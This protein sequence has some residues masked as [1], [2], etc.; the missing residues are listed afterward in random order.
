MKAPCCEPLLM[1]I[2]GGTGDLTHRMV[3]PA[4]FRLAARGHLDPKSQIVVA[5]RRA[6]SDEELRQ[7]SMEAIDQEVQDRSAETAAW[8]RAS[9]HYRQ[10]EQQDAD[11]MSVFG[12]QLAAFEKESGL[13]G[14]RVFYL[15]LPPF[16]FMPTVEALGEAGLAR[17]GGWTRIVVEKPFGR[18]L[19]SAE[20]LNALLHRYFNEPQIF[21][22]DHYLG[23]ETVQ[24]LLVFRLANPIFE[25]LWNRDRIESVQITVSETLGVENR[26]AFY[27]S[28]GALRDMIQNHL[29]QL[30]CLIAMEV[31]TSFHPEEIRDEKVKVL[32][33]VAPL[34]AADA[35]FGQYGKGAIN[36]GA[37][38]GYRD[39]P[40]VARKSVTETFVALRLGV[41][42]WRWQGVP[43]YLRVGK[44]MAR[45]LSQI[46][47]QF[48][49]P[50]VMVFQPFE[51][52]Q[53]NS[54]ALTITLQPDEGFDLCFEVK[55]PGQEIKVRSE[56]LHFRYAEAFGPLP[57]AYET[58][59]LDIMRGDQ[60]LFVR[61]DWV[62]H[63][64]RL[65]A[66]LLETPPPL[67]TYAAGTWGPKKANELLAPTHTSWLPE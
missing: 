59:L 53:V 60:T 5:G 37:V 51:G 38:P 29:T 61:A 16:A 24:N 27:E 11:H 4:L 1:V 15:S 54:N 41:E 64:W 12:G 43:F 56:R 13:T 30:L 23:K 6:I 63:S 58:L 48:R 9:L 3:L 36:G 8:F 42:N 25:T 52:C 17:S 45:R 50:P 65:Y 35:V 49:R 62:E 28:S 26:A 22:I 55:E 39:E 18:D 67:E 44:R 19:K 34:A 32:R 2:F 7:R 57:T 14:N 21:R 66:P 40:A 33:A 47:I 46:V 31:P 10:L 20:E